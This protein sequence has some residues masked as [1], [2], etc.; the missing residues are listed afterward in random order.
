MN[1]LGVC[2]KHRT[3]DRVEEN[4]P[5]SGLT[6]PVREGMEWLHGRLRSMRSG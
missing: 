5:R 2:N 1:G 3:R 4:I 6:A